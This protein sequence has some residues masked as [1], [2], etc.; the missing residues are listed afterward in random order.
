MACIGRKTL[1]DQRDREDD[2]WAVEIT[3]R[4]TCLRDPRHNILNCILTLEGG[5]APATDTPRPR[6]I[7]RRPHDRCNGPAARPD[8]ALMGTI[9][10]L[11]AVDRYPLPDGAREPI[12]RPM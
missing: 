4:V 7:R 10:A 2:E 11:F 5:L 12:E 1:R 6:A 8:D 9:A 3:H